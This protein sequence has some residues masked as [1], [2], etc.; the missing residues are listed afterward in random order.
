MAKVGLKRASA[1]DFVGGESGVLVLGKLGSAT[2]RI[3][4]RGSRARA[5]AR[6]RR[7]CGIFGTLS[8]WPWPGTPRCGS[9]SA[10]FCGSFATDKGSLGKSSCGAKASCAAESTAAAPRASQRYRQPLKQRL[11]EC[12]S[13]RPLRLRRR[14][15]LSWTQEAPWG[16]EGHSTAWWWSASL[17]EAGRTASAGPGTRSRTTAASRTSRSR[18]LG[19]DLLLRL[20]APRLPPPL[21]RPL[22][23][24]APLKATKKPL[25]TKK[26]S[27]TRR[28]PW[29]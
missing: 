8:C 19:P 11:P 5:C 9:A 17:S 15:W 18:P 26:P 14:R 20:G 16:C 23:L 12:Q 25:S 7:P 3:A 24:L 21:T 1:P 10:S 2:R 4:R 27:L 28:F 29:R 13:Q 22:A 6:A